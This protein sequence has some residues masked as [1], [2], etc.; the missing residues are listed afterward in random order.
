MPASAPKPEMTLWEHSP[1]PGK[2]QGGLQSGVMR[3]WSH[4]PSHFPPD[5]GFLPSCP[6]RKVRP[7]HLAPG[8]VV[9]PPEKPSPGSAV[10][11]NKKNYSFIQKSSC[12]DAFLSPWPKIP[13]TP[14]CLL[15]LAWA[16]VFFALWCLLCQLFKGSYHVSLAKLY[17]FKVFSSLHINLGLPALQH[18]PKRAVQCLLWLGSWKQRNFSLQNYWHCVH[19]ISLPQTYSHRELR[20]HDPVY[21]CF[22]HSTGPFSPPDDIS[23]N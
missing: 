3:C 10:S 21:Y 9:G 15:G 22:K 8:E 4:W 17:M 1:L 16:I 2:L 14:N 5:L 7:T 23:L 19:F 6:C 12:Q 18:L 11:W 13:I 20:R